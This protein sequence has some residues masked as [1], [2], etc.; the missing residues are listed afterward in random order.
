[1]ECDDVM[2]YLSELIGD[3]LNDSAGLI[4]FVEVPTGATD[5]LAM[6]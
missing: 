3:G 6:A 4:D 5:V 2:A 1:M